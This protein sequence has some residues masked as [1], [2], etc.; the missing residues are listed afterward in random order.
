MKKITILL[1]EDHVVVRE[2]FRQFLERETSFEVIGVIEEKGSAGFMNP[3]DTVII[4]FFTGQGR[5]WG[6]NT[7]SGIQISGES[8][9]ASEVAKASVTTVR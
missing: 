9:E 3:D 4:P 1:A 7:L 6:G 5:L 8:P 2:S